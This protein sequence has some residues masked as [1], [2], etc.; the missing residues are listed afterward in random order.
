MWDCRAALLEQCSCP[1]ALQPLPPCKL[2]LCCRLQS[3]INNNWPL[4]SCLL[5]SSHGAHVGRQVGTVGLTICAC[6]PRCWRHPDCLACSSMVVPQGLS[7]QGWACGRCSC[8]LGAA[9]SV[10]ARDGKRRP[11]GSLHASP[12]A[13][14]IA[15]LLLDWELQEE[16]AK[17]NGSEGR[18]ELTVEE[19]KTVE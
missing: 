19:R 10:C 8:R 5:R 4:A 18:A 17:E 14:H 7:L 9:G 2:H 16:G 15:G 12:E 13:Q 11:G 3:A 1:Q 6:A